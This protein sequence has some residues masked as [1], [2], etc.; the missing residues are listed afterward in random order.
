MS[1]CNWCGE[2][3]DYIKEHGKLEDQLCGACLGF[4]E[5]GYTY[6]DLLTGKYEEEEDEAYTRWKLFTFFL[7]DPDEQ[8][9][10]V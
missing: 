9:R 3:G 1:A 10:L 5:R 8:G 6:E 2:N 7:L 4:H